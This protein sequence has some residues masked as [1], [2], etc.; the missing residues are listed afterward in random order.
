M[1]E[2][3]VLP[4]TGVTAN[5]VHDDHGNQIQL[6][7]TLSPDDDIVTYYHIFRSRSLELTEPIPLDS[8]GSIEELINLEENNTILIDSVPGG[9]SSYI[10]RFIPTNGVTYFYWLQAE[11][12]TGTSEKVA[13]KTRIITTHVDDIP[14]EFKIH[15]PHPNPFNPTTAIRY[16]IPIECH[17][18]LIVYDILGRIVFILKDSYVTSGIHQV[19][20]DGRN[21][22]GDYAGNGVYIIHL[23]AGT[24]VAQSKVMLLR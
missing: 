21:H 18:K 9:E 3:K 23:S 5:D 7:W 2:L 8:L 19:V 14:S 22:T 4:P 24:Y 11:A 10:D 13:T 15:P 1:K 12:P 17:A 6:T 16:E 20:W